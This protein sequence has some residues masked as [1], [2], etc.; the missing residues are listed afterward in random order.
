MNR[1]SPTEVPA[2]H[3]RRSFLASAASLGLW[4]A[5]RGTV[6]SYALGPAVAVGRAS[7]IPL[8]DRVKL[9]IAE[10]RI[11]LGSEGATATAI[12]GTVPGP[13]LR[14]REG[15]EA[16]IEVTNGL[17]EDTSIHWHGL[18]LPP[19]MD[20]VPGVSFAG[21]K[22]GES[23][24]YRF[25]INQSGTYWYHSHSGLQEQT[26]VYGPL[27]VDP[28]EPEPY[29]YERDYVVL[30]SD[31]TFE[32]PYEILANLKKQSNYYNFQQRTLGTLF[33]DV[34]QNG[35]SAAIGDR[36]MWG[37]MRMDPTDISDITGYTYTYLVNGLPPGANW[38]G[39]FARGE[40]IRLRFINAGAASYFDV[41][42]PGLK[43]TVVQADGQDIQ[44][45]VVDELRIAIAET[46]DVI[47]EPGEGPAYTIFAEAM[48]RSGFARGTLAVRDGL[49][50]PIPERRPR[51]L[52]SMADMGMGM[53]HGG[54]HGGGHGEHGG[55]HGGPKP[56]APH[57]MEHGADAHAAGHGDRRSAMQ[58]GAAGA[59]NAGG[60]V[61]HG[62]EDHGPGN[63]MVPDATKDRTGEPG[64]GLEGSGR[65]VLLYA[66]LRSLSPGSDPRPPSREI[67]LH[68]T[69][70]M[71]RYMW[72]FDGK[73]YS[74]ADGPIRFFYGERLRLTLVNDTMMNHPIHL[75]GMWFELV[76]GSGAHKPRKHTV[77]VKPA[78]RLSVD[79]TADA[80]GDWAFH[81][82]ILYHMEMG[83]FR[84]V[85]VA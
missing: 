33:R 59:A 7:G 27:I 76:N 66:D 5:L 71:E 31:W 69:G 56:A 44:P 80:R 10:T 67:E 8:G 47:V 65:R 63:A 82:H 30:L 46:Y 68:L 40:R 61:P 35:W 38:T 60:A 1:R 22:P 62:P 81:C 39:V 23:F 2:Y 36:L 53:D 75:H 41:R 34:E 79:I 49:S 43:M 45:V 84:V 17:R 74:E 15:Q 20:G 54:G 4:A 73:K 57:V 25:S 14:F 12:N 3:S 70:N 21:I 13:L 28:K 18:I 72:S 37:Q 16:I 64:I 42:I 78:E 58:H 24:T 26:G 51:P 9:G 11:N 32:D 52:L 29:A 77:N 50:A 19:G 48:D 83:M 55:G 85:T 6:P